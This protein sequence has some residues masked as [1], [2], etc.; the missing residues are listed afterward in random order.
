MSQIVGEFGNI[1][2]GTSF[3]QRLTFVIVILGFIAG[4]LAVTFW[5]R[6]PDY[7]LLYSD[8]SQRE[9][10]EVVAY[11]R[12]N[13]I[14]YKVKDNGSTVL[15]PANK[16][17]ESRMVLAENSLPRGEVG[18]ELFD[19]VKF[20]MSDLAQRINYRRALQ[21]ELSKTIAQLDGVE[22]AKVQ[23]VIPEPSLF[24][25]DE[26][27]STA[28]VVIKM[29]KRNGL[30]P[31]M[32]A[33]ITHL[34]STSVEGL[35]TEDIT[36]T[37]NRGNLLSTSGESKMSGEITNQFGLS[38]KIEDHYAS[39]A[40]SIIEKMTGP[41]KAIVKVSA[42]LEFKHLDEKQ[43]EYDNEKKVPISQV[44]TTQSTEMPQGN[45]SE[46]SG[47]MSKEAE[48]TETTQYALSKVER[49]V[50]EH[51]AR[52]KRLT[53]A[54]LVDGNYEEGEN[55]DGEV[56]S[57]YIPRTE[58]ELAQIAAIVKQ[59]IGLDESAPR[60]D[61][62]EIQSV[63]F[64]HHLPVYVDEESVAKADKK[65]FILSIARSSSLVIAVLAFLLFAKKA[66][67]SVIVPRRATAGVNY[68]TYDAPPELEEQVNEIDVARQ[69][70][71]KREVVRDGIIDNTKAYPKTTSNLVRKW[72][73]ES[74]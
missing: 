61:K 39:K 37:D 72:L 34:V 30:R 19:K 60:N 11:L 25:K 3:G 7:G 32:I 52:I 45:N 46:A 50:S 29:R 49:V 35:S 1:W 12:D 47:G 44:I 10:G 70:N 67:K 40:M 66:L 55:A 4:L 24:I 16:I 26:K 27:P 59:A 18:F 43:I 33:G 57:T 13:N 9:A 36:I 54:V 8:L 51:E 69:G 17:Y 48:E 63:E 23:I 21:G 73:R 53:V 15:V 2:K 65:E 38:R 28:S 68:A 41:G 14:P 6:T 71:E 20:G 64:Q 58:E 31:E 5:V 56:T 42:D 74:D 62:F 22:W